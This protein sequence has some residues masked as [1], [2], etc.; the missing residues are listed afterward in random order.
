M[1]K[2]NI[3]GIHENVTSYLRALQAKWLLIFE[4]IY[5]IFPGHNCALVQS[6]A[7]KTV[8]FYNI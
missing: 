6:S 8:T 1:Y 5:T 4:M 2:M 7:D 3:S